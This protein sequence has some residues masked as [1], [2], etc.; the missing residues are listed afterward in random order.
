MNDIIDV[1]SS[2]EER[3]QGLKAWGWISYV[4]HLIVAV[5]AVIPGAQPGAALLIIAL[6]IDLVKRGDAQNTWQASH[7]SWRIRTVLWAG[8][9]YLLTAP[10]WLLLFLPGWIAWALISIWFLY[11]IVRGMVDM[12]RNQPMQA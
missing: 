8:V 5:G 11:R 2:D 1:P 4:L 3:A 7:F 12:N 6:V 9:L 10:L